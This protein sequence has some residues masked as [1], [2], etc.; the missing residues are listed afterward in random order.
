[1]AV[2]I[3]DPLKRCAKS[4]VLMGEYA[5]ASLDQYCCSTLEDLRIVAEVEQFR[6]LGCSQQV[7]D[8]PEG[9]VTYN[10]SQQANKWFSVPRS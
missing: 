10:T 3:L 2:P 7:Q 6:L 4:L 8:H 5:L 1:M 9:P